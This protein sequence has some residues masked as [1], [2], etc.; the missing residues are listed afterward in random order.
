VRTAK[1]IC[2]R[3]KIILKFAPWYYFTKRRAH[4][5]QKK[6][7]RAQVPRGG[8]RSLTEAMCREAIFTA[9]TKLPQARM[10]TNRTKPAYGHGLG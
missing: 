7:A 9:G 4:R 8:F 10:P 2:I 1:K 3:A 5:E 6:V